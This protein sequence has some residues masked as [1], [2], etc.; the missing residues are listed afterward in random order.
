[1]RIT[2]RLNAGPA[3]R[4]ESQGI[5]FPQV[6]RYDFRV[7][8]YEQRPDDAS[9]DEFVG[10][11]VGISRGDRIALSLQGGSSQ[12][13]AGEL[14]GRNCDLRV[15]LEGRSGVDNRSDGVDHWRRQIHDDA[16]FGR[17]P[18]PERLFRRLLGQEARDPGCNVRH[19][20][21]ARAAARSSCARWSQRL[22]GGSGCGSPLI[23]DDAVIR[24]FVLS[25]PDDEPVALKSPRRW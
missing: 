19:A 13:V 24:R 12:E 22:A 23:D 18:C 9:C 1:M 8:R 14:A 5:S 15:S 21:M 17:Y 25:G 16:G 10:M 2:R 4:V 3:G 6:K 11:R 7:M 20:R